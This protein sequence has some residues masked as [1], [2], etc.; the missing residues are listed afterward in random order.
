[1]SGLA[2]LAIA[3]SPDRPGKDDPRLAPTLAALAALAR[4]D[5]AIA[6]KDFPGYTTAIALLVLAATGAHPELV[7]PAQRWLADHQLD[8]GEGSSPSDP[9]YG[10]IG[11]GDDGKTDLSN[12]H[13]ALE[14]LHETH[15]KDRPEV[16]ARALTFLSR[17]QNWSET[18][19]QP[20]AGNDGGFVYRPGESKAGGT[21]SSGSMTYA[22]LKSLVYASVARDDPR[23][24]AA[25]VWISAHYSVDENP[26]LGKKGLYYYYQA[27]ARALALLGEPVLT[28]AAGVR[29]DWYGELTRKLLAMQA[30]D[31]SWKNDDP[32]YWESNPVL[33]TS[34]AL[35]ALEY[36][37]ATAG[38]GGGGGGTK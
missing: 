25:L 5:G 23:V 14:A 18:N 17:C 34:R 2:A 12:L 35:L 27:F 11:Y 8:E 1:V 20:W 37:W 26:G 15:F 31:G 6:G 16:Y 33:A 32:T 3:L 19:D 7:A 29:H 13:F 10:G 22:G 4:P 24:K 9:G 28:D 36:G 30:A 21:A 38:G